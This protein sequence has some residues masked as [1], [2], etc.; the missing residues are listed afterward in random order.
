MEQEITHYSRGKLHL[1]QIR[2]RPFNLKG[3]AYGFLFR[4]EIFFRTTRIKKNLSHKARTF[5]QEFNITLYHKN[6]ES[7]YSFRKKTNNPPLQVKWSFPN[8]EVICT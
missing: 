7:D 8:C 4:S 3:R 2:D 6:S 1:G 5:F